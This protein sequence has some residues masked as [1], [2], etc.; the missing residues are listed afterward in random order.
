MLKTIPGAL[1]ILLVF[2]A[3][4]G[5]RPPFGLAHGMALDRANRHCFAWFPIDPY[6]QRCENVYIVPGWTH[7]NASCRYFSFVTERNREGRVIRTRI[8][9]CDNSHNGY[10]T[11]VYK[12]DG[13]LGGAARVKPVRENVVIRALSWLGL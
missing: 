4:A 10:T 9:S 13:Y 12:N 3:L 6:S 5:A 2:P 8:K 11:V 7:A 1:A